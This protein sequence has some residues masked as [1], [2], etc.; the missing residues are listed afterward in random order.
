MCGG[1]GQGGA[2]GQGGER[3]YVRLCF[4]VPTTC[5]GARGEGEQGG[6]RGSEGARGSEGSESKLY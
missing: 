2:R 6:V 1:K 5:V 4:R 3:G